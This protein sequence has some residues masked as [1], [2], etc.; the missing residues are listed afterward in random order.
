MESSNTN[1][2]IQYKMESSRTKLNRPEPKG[3][4]QNKM[5]LSKTNVIIQD[6][7]ESSKTN[8]SSNANGIIK[9]NGIIQY[10]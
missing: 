1:V 6:K 8:G 3:F 7:V 10:K 5:E 2:L 4:V 9:K